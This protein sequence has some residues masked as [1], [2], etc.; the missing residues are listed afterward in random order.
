MASRGTEVVPVPPEA[1]DFRVRVADPG[2]S[3]AEPTLG[4]AEDGTIYTNPFTDGEDL[5]KSIDGGQTWER[6]GSQVH[7]PKV[8]FDPWMWLDRDTGRVYNGPLYV[9]CSHLAWSDDGGESWDSNPVAGCGLPAHD[10]QKITTGPPAP[11]VGTDGYP[12][13]V[14]YAYNG[15]FRSDFGATG[16][17]AGERLSGTW[18]TVSYDGGETF[19]PGQ[20][21]IEPD[22]CR[23]GINGPVNVGPDGTAYLPKATCQGTKVVVSRDSG[24]SWELST[25]ITSTGMYGGLAVNPDVDTD[26]AGNAYL[27]TP[28]GDGQMYLSTTTDRGGSWSEPVRVTP[29]QVNFTVFSVVGVGQE[30]HVSVAYLGTEANVSTWDRPE[31]SYASD[32]TAWQL[33]ISTSQDALAE[34]PTWVT[35]QVTPDGDPVQRGCVWLYGGGNECRNLLDFIDLEEHDGRTYVAYSDGCDGCESADESRDSV[36]K[37]AIV[38]EGPSLQGGVLDPLVPLDEAPST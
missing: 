27:A 8:N 13:V 25:H 32:D 31:P 36:H 15:A 1:E 7:N 21:A 34:D 10:H 11:D 12:N 19:T 30:G 22:D 38:E 29:P 33:Y 24:S 4:V 5:L 9:G 37:V 16:L 18:V 17:E 28:G 26:P 20:R 6:V 3:G 14:Y 35:R 2:F 23:G